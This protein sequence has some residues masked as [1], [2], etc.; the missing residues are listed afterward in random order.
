MIVEEKASWKNG[1]FF[2]EGLW[3]K[4]QGESGAV[5]CHPHPLMGGSMYKQC[6]GNHP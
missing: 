3:R 1:L 4:G 5:I 2:A 6:R